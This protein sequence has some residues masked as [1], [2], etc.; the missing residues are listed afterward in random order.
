LLCFSEIELVDHEK[1]A[2]ASLFNLADQKRI[3]SSRPW[4]WEE[5]ALP[6][7]LLVDY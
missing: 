1:F 4:I 7:V 6:T 2:P 5:R 3:Q